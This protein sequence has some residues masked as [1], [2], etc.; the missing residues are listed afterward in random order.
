MSARFFFLCDKIHT[1][2]THLDTILHSR[3]VE[4]CCTVFPLF[5][6]EKLRNILRSIAYRCTNVH[7]FCA[8]LKKLQRHFVILCSRS[9]RACGWNFILCVR[10]SVNG[11]ILLYSVSTQP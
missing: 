5:S 1:T 2:I 4:A 7:N 3:G 11:G 9:F 8:F 6:R 10:K